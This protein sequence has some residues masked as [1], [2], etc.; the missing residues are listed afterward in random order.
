MALSHEE[1][2]HEAGSTTD[3]DTPESELIRLIVNT[4]STP[5]RRNSTYNEFTE[6]HS[7]ESTGILLPIQVGE[8]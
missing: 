3:L 8:I 6:I 7:L 1:I 5:I 4:G 2:M